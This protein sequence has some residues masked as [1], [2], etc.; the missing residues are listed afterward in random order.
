MKFN[1]TVF[2]VSLHTDVT[3][4]NHGICCLKKYSLIPEM[5]VLYNYE[6]LN[7][8]ISCCAILILQQVGAFT[9]VNKPA[10]KFLLL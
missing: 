4:E 2:G 7:C 1:N 3:R 8:T 5:E 10:P 9:V 6:Y